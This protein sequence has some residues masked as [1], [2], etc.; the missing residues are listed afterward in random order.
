MYLKCFRIVCSVILL[1]PYSLDL[2]VN[3]FVFDKT[4]TL[5]TGKPVVVTTKL[6]KKMS[7]KDFYEAVAAAE[8]S[9][10]PFTITT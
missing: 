2:Q 8:A 10:T 5:T 6:F 9:L 1:F 7:L 3:C 4:G